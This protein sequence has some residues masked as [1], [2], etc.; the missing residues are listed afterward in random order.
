MESSILLSTKK[1]L[2]LDPS[3]DA[4]DLDVLTHINTAF[5]IL[6]QLG[7]GPED[8]FMIEDSTTQWDEY[9]EDELFLNMVKTYVYLKTSVLF[10]P[11][12]TGFLIDAKNKQ[13]AEL[14]WRLSISREE[15]SV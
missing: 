9:T 1:I 14:E 12:T 5:A 13:V 6:Q 3:Y 15:E 7:I 4:F 2:G 10:D 8:G 11:P